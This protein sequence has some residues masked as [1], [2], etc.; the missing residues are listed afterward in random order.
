MHEQEENNLLVNKEIVQFLNL[1]LGNSE[2]TAFFYLQELYPRASDYFGVS[3]EDLESI[4][5]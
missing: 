4:D 2:E 5:I 1:F 3:I